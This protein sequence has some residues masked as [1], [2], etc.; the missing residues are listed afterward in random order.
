ML[1]IIMPVLISVIFV[2]MRVAFHDSEHLTG[3]IAGINVIALCYVVISLLM[4]IFQAK[5]R[6]FRDM[7][8]LEETIRERQRRYRWISIVFSVLCVLCGIGYT[9]CLATGMVNDILS[10]TALCLSLISGPLT[11]CFK[12][13]QWDYFSIGE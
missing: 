4:G 7:E 6:R 12:R 10:I 2:Y 1:K 8:I 11:E 5:V 13:D 9:L 3:M